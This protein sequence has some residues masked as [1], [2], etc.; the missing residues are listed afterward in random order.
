[1]L[2]ILILLLIKFETAL[3]AANKLGSAS[4]SSFWTTENCK[5]ALAAISQEIDEHNKHN[6]LP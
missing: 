3:D 1:M 5:S 4:L 2:N 6:V